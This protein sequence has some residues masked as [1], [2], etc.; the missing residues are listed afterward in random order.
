MAVT[1]QAGKRTRK[2]APKA[3]AVTPAELATAAADGQPSPNGEVAAP[4]KAGKPSTA[5]RARGDLV[6]VESPTKAKTL[7]R[8][9]GPNYL[10]EASF[11]HIR[12]LP[13]SKIGIDPKTFAPEYV[14]PPDSEKHARLL[15]R[16]ARAADRVWLASD[17]DREGEAIAWHVAQIINVPAAKLRRVTFHEITPDAIAE[18][19]RKPRQ[20]DQDLVDAQQARRVVDRLVGYTMSPLLWKKIRYGLSAGRVQSVALRLIVDREREIQKFTPVEYWSL[21]ALLANHAGESFQAEVIQHKGHKL[22]IGNAAE[23]EKHRAA[24]AD[25]VYR[26]ASIEK[27]ESSRSAGGPYTTSTLQQDASRK[28]GYSVK[29]TMVLAQQLYEG[30]SLGDT[31]VGLITYMR[32]DSLHVAEGALK[33]SKDVIVREFGAAYALEK[34]R[35]FKTRSKGAQEA[36]EA[37]RPTDL[38]RTPD[39]VKRYLNKDQLRLYTLIW[40]RT[41]ASQMA[42]AKFENT[43]LD[44]S[45]DGYTLRAN[46]RRVTFDG[47]LRVYQ[48]G[49]DEPEKEQ[50]PLPAVVEGEELKLLGLDA[51]QHFTQPPARFNEASL[52]KTLEEHGIGR[53]ST[54]APT[55]STLIDRHYVRREQRALVPEDVGFTVVDF[56]TEHFPD[57][58]DLG[59][60]ARMELDLDRVA[61]GEVEWAPVVRDFFV[62]FEKL[63]KEKAASVKKSDVTEEATDKVCPKCG[64]PVIIK[65]GRYGRFYSCTGFVKGK[66]GQP[67]PPGGCD[68]S[69]PLEGEEQG[70]EIVEGEVCPDCGKPLAKKRGRFGP[71]IGCTGYPDCKYI[72]KNVQKTGVTCPLCGQGELV[73]RRGRGRSVFY[74]CERY[75]DCTFTARELPASAEQPAVPA[76]AEA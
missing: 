14:I 52:V 73:R 43:R 31:P 20:I 25:A 50:V 66:K 1:K 39:R 51:A 24:L 76:A 62:P 13:K 71:F 74:G 68:Y 55:I 58:V 33:Q 38:S 7:G 60:T 5:P 35:H 28:L 41:L 12:D 6:V 47:F 44:V 18:A 72:K 53:P 65:L 21:D 56:L 36:H 45:A 67:T 16:E 48:E 4:A 69:A 11:G 27:R 23:A 54:Y 61:A 42:P 2:T 70:P 22:A 34:P 59:F 10:V 37:I 46:G 63:V 17:L 40:Q 30:V 64:R 3:H 26:I 49:T 29:R 57:I 19:F 8:M 15:K 75:P 9:L 32:T